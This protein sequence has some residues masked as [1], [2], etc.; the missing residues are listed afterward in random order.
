MIGRLRIQAFGEHRLL[1]W[2][3][4]AAACAGPLVFDLVQH[5]YTVAIPRYAISGLPFACL[6]AAVGFACINRRLRFV[7]LILIILAWT[8]TFLRIY[9]SRWRVW[10]PFRGNLTNRLR[11]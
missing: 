10:S 6:L 1:L 2:L 9:Y 3:S 5:T 11:E 7:V 8:P 4:F